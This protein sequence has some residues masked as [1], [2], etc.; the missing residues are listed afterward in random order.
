MKQKQNHINFQQIELFQFLRSNI[1]WLEQLRLHAHAC[2]QEVD[3]LLED[4]QKRRSVGCMWTGSRSPGRCCTAICE[5][6]LKYKKKNG[7]IFPPLKVAS[8]VASTTPRNCHSALWREP[9]DGVRSNPSGTN[10]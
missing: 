2:G 4:E 10:S 3:L 1:F 6:M 9:T 7:N 5:H 8:L